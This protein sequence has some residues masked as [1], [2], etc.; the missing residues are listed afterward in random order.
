MASHF[1]SIPLQDKILIGAGGVAVLT[2]SLI[3]LYQQIKKLYDS[4]LAIESE[5]AERG[6][7]IDNGTRNYFLNPSVEAPSFIVSLSN[8]SAEPLLKGARTRQSPAFILDG[9]A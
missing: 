2:E 8:P 4:S 3:W 1:R 6:V 5:T 9:H 7:S